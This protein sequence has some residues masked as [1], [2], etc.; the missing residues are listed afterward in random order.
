MRTSI[1]T[2]L[3]LIFGINSYSQS[4]I[5]IC[6]TDSTSKRV[7]NIKILIPFR[8]FYNSRFVKNDHTLTLK[9]G[10]KYCLGIL[11]EGVVQLRGNFETLLIP[12]FKGDSI[13]VFINTKKQEITFT[14]KGACGINEYGQ[15]QNSI[16]PKLIDAYDSTSSKDEYLAKISC[17]IEN[18]KVPFYRYFMNG[19]MSK[20]HLQHAIYY[21][22]N[23]FYYRIMTTLMYRV[24]EKDWVRHPEKE[25]NELVGLL[26]DKYDPFQKKYDNS[27]NAQNA[28]L[29]K[30]TLMEWNMIPFKVKHTIWDSTS[31]QC[32]NFLPINSQEPFLGNELI[33][34]ILE[35][36]IAKIKRFETLL[37]KHFPNSEYLKETNEEREPSIE[38]FDKKKVV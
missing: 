4:T 28:K 1:L 27:S 18:A 13:S 10:E 25:I 21:K 24:K 23:T 19:S 33:N 36:D 30:C 3:F 22:E 37:L 9:G 34:A 11:N 35:K 14:G 31:F 5:T 6:N 26:D 29:T 32:L 17:M 16:V 2:L 12:I 15:I 38:K 7:E 20:D 8:N